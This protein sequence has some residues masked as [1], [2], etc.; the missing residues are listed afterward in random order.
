[1]IEFTE[2]EKSLLHLLTEKEMD[3]IWKRLQGEMKKP[4]RAKK[5][6]EEVFGK[7]LE[8][9]EKSFET[10][11]IEIKDQK[12]IHSVDAIED[13]V[14]E[15]WKSRALNK[16]VVKLICQSGLKSSKPAIFTINSDAIKIQG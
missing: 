13:W 14:F 9:L 2:E 3:T 4:K 8:A 7:N 6:M 16:A 1:M 5:I 11:Y 12:Y 15:T 10:G